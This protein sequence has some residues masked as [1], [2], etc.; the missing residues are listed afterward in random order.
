MNKSIKTVGIL[1]LIT[2]TIFAFYS[3]STGSKK[4]SGRLIFHEGNKCS[5]EVKMYVNT[6]DGLTFKQ[7]GSG[8]VNDEARSLTLE[9]VEQGTLIYIYDSPEGSKDDDWC[10][11]KAKKNIT[12]RCIDSFQHN[13]KDDEVELVFYGNNNSPNAL[14]GKV[15]RIEVIKFF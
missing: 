12:R 8:F 2:P 11:I 9:N 13:I 6:Q 7:G 3:S 10:T 15:S 1:C 4:A 5:Q 14:D